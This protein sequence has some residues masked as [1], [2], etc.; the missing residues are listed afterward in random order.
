L[1]A[2][3]DLIPAGIRA[4][5]FDAVG[6]LLHPDPVP[7]L[8]YAEVGRQFGSQHG[9]EVI[10]DRFGKAFARQ[11]AEDRK[12]GW[13]TSEKREQERWRSIVSEVLDDVRDAD[14]CFEQ[15]FEHFGRPSA[16]GCSAE[17]E[18]VLAQLQLR[19]Y[20]LAIASNYDSRLFEVVG[21][22]PELRRVT[23][24]VISATAGW[25]KPAAGFFDALCRR[26]ELAP[27]EVLY[28]G[29]DLDNDYH[30]ALVSGLQ[31][32]LFDPEDRAVETVTRCTN[33]KDLL[34]SRIPTSNPS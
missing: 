30:G 16:W 19:G 22:K 33:L 27:R 21:G 7:A 1:S 15:L 20:R 25:R 29:D 4:V 17:T 31:A 3:H 10:A 14:S 18:D 9:P 26:L 32:V 24:V 6:T 23:D 28:V 13:R 2:P 5:V 8:V 11:E 34:G 12:V